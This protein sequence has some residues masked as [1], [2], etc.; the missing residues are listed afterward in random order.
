MNGETYSFAEV[1]GNNC[2]IKQCGDAQL[3]P[4]FKMVLYLKDE[5]SLHMDEAFKVIYYSSVRGEEVKD[6]KFFG[7]EPC[8]LYQEEEQRE[9][10]KQ[11]L[12]M[13]CQFNVYMDLGIEGTYN[14]NLKENIFT[15]CDGQMIDLPDDKN[16]QDNVEMK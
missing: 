10:I 7:F 3:S 6:C 4:V 11:Y 16:A 2:P 1:V 14:G 15:L 9:K 12:H 13:L 5:A 8:N